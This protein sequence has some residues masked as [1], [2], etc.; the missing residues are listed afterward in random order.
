MTTFP[1]GPNRE[2]I[3]TLSSFAIDS[4]QLLQETLP[5][6]TFSALSSSYCKRLDG[7]NN[8][9]MTV[10]IPDNYWN[11]EESQDATVTDTRLAAVSYCPLWCFHVELER[12]TWIR[13]P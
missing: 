1:G 4:A 13:Q 6:T 8:K 2:Y 10:G 12:I 9:E 3:Q 7:C 11:V 5:G